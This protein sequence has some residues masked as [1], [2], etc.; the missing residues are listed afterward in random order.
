[1]LSRGPSEEDY[2]ADYAGRRVVIRLFT[3]EANREKVLD[4]ARK[5]AGLNHPNIALQ[6]VG[7]HED[8]PFLM[9]ELVGKSLETWNADEQALP[10]Q[11]AVIEGVAL[12]LTHAHAQGVVHRSLSPLA[13]AHRTSVSRSVA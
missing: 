12:A 6:E 4:E 11:M 10:D 1:M 9:S 7:I 3:T 5:I 8:Q 2:T 13:S